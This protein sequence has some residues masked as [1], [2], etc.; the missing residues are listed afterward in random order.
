[1]CY[2]AGRDCKGSLRKM[3]NQGYLIARTE[4]RFKKKK[5]GFYNFWPVSKT[6]AHIPFYITYPQVITLNFLYCSQW[7]LLSITENKIKF[8]PAERE[9]THGGLG[10]FWV[11]AVWDAGSTFAQVSFN[12]LLP[13]YSSQ[14]REVVQMY[15]SAAPAITLGGGG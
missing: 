4:Q 6:R 5:K 11:A 8:L 13:L 9:A 14:R 12:F 7:A 15:Q 10:C 2:W 1:M 3:N